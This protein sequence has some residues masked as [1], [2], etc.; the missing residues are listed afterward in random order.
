MANEQNLIPAVKGEPSRN[1]KGR[2]KGSFDRVTIIRRVLDMPLDDLLDEDERP[3][4]L[5]KQ[6]KKTV[7][8]A[9]NIRMA[10]SSINGD[11]QA[12]NALTKA[13]G[14][15]IDVNIDY[16]VALVEFIGD[17]DDEDDSKG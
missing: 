16:P 4:W 10:L 11:T 1:P 9:M 8:E 2:P 15:K 12:Y 7:Y 17:D 3:A 5:K 13:L 6:R 14:D